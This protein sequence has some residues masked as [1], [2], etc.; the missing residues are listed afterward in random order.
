MGPVIVKNMMSIFLLCASRCYH[1]H[2]FTD[3]NIFVYTYLHFGIYHLLAMIYDSRY[4][5]R[6]YFK[7][8]PM[9][10]L[11]VIFSKEY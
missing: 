10:T 9:Y 5:K 6:S 8:V 2:V 11:L 4:L 3:E 1:S 7:N